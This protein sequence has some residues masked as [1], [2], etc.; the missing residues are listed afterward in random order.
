MLKD[1][2][3]VEVLDDYRVRL[4]FEDGVEGEVDLARVLTFEGVFA[5]LT[6]RGE[7][8]K[9]AVHPELGTICWP[10]GADLDPDVLYALVTGAPMPDLSGAGTS[11]A[12]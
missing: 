1:V 12:R 9:V 4:R 2:V 8:R 11:A 10:N 6:D 3:A 7:F 5:S